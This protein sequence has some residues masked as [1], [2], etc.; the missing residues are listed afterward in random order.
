MKTFKNFLLASNMNRGTASRAKKYRRALLSVIITGLMGLILAF[1]VH[2]QGPGPYRFSLVP[3]SNTIAACLPNAAATVTVFPKEDL[4][5]VDTLDLK[6]E[7]LLAN[8]TFTVF[9]TELAEGPFGAAQYIG[10]FTTNAAGRGSVRVDAVIEEAFSST[11]VEGTRV[12]KE[13]N[14]IVLWF[15]DPAADD[16]CFAPASGPTTPFDGDGQAGGTALS[17]RNFNP[18]APLP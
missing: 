1:T 6:A 8:T 3:T 11:V 5:G 2:A 17:S 7:G 9:L 15:A 13:L 4:H 10:E 12:R 14:H 16:V 18:G